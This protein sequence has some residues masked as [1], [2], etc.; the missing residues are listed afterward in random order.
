VHNRKVILATKKTP[1]RKFSILNVAAAGCAVAIASG[2][3]TSAATA[4]SATGPA[5]TAASATGPAATAAS[6][7]GPAAAA[8][9]YQGAVLDAYTR[10]LTGDYSFGALEHIWM[11][12]GGSGRTAS[13]AACIAER[14]SSG[15][16]NAISPTN[17]WGLWQIHNGGRRMLNPAANAAAAVRMSD[18]GR[19][20]SAWT[21]ARWC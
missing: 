20:W 17:D 1:N 10:P 13:H 21:T 3:A 8:E 11:A 9:P 2:A 12:V 7:T 16:P 5:A 19:N 4:A 6:A 14:E 18:N 15:N